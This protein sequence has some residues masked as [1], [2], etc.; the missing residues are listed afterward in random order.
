MPALSR[1]SFS[2]WLLALVPAGLLARVGGAPAPG[3]PP[4][5]ESP[6]ASAPP[7]DDRL[8]AA[9]AAAVLPSELGAVGITRAAADFQRWVAGYKEGAELVHG[10]GTAVIGKTVAD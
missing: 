6:P 4:P 1:R 7:F 10:Y 8:V 5:N 2:A 3:P 9:L